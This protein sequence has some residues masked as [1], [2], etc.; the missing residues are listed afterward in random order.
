MA[1]SDTDDELLLAI[2]ASVVA[3]IAMEEIQEIGIWTDAQRDGC[4]AEYKWRCLHA[5]R[6]KVWLT[7]TTRVPCSNIANRR[8]QDLNAK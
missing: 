6:R 3:V 8:T 2:N 4:P 5:Q 7:P 1:D